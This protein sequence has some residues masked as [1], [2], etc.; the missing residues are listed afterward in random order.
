MESQ[1]ASD[2]GSKSDESGSTASSPAKRYEVRKRVRALTGTTRSLWRRLSRRSARFRCAISNWIRRWRWL[3][4]E[5]RESRAQAARQLE[6]SKEKMVRYRAGAG[7]SALPV[8]KRS[9]AGFGDLRCQRAHRAGDSQR[10][11]ES[12]NFC[13][14]LNPAASGESYRWSRCRSI[15]KAT[16]SERW[17]FIS[18]E[19]AASPN[20]TSTPAS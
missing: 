14:T 17:N 8:G 1:S 19:F 9:A 2:S 20:R 13:L 18:T 3:P 6:F 4:R 5:W 16:L 12:P 15:T 11:C 7:A 10:G